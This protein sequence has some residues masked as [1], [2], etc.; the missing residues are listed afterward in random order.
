[1]ASQKVLL[2]LWILVPLRLTEKVHHRSLLLNE[3]TT[4][5]ISKS[6]RALVIDSSQSNVIFWTDCDLG[7][8]II[9]RLITVTLLQMANYY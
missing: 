7:K 8:S 6:I 3:K 4:A 9:Y 1:M 2:L 5:L